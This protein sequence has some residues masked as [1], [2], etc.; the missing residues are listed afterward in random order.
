M[1]LS[2][3]R[4]FALKPPFVD[5]LRVFDAACRHRRARSAILGQRA[6]AQHDQLPGC[7]P[8]LSVLSGVGMIRWGAPSSAPTTNAVGDEEFMPTTTR[9]PMRS[10]TARKARKRERLVETIANARLQYGFTQQDLADA[11]GISQATISQIE[12]GKTAPGLA[13]QEA[14]LAAIARLTGVAGV[15]PAAGSGRW[16][17]TLS[18]F[19]S[20]ANF[21]IDQ[22]ADRTGIPKVRLSE[23]ENGRAPLGLQERQILSRVVGCHPEDLHSP[24][25]GVAVTG[26]AIF[27]SHDMGG[28]QIADLHP[29]A[30]Y[31]AL[32][33]LG[34]VEAPYPPKQLKPGDPEVE[35][36]AE[37]KLRRRR[38]GLSQ[39]QLAALAGISQPL[40][41]AIEAGKAPIP[42]AV[43]SALAQSGHR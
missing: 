11:S 42:E 39:A 31:R 21:T 16:V 30:R 23:V 41:S 12:A 33:E 36:A 9:R 34:V 17:Q 1:S 4:Q 13:T 15:D 28:R 7:S 6:T 37:L 3:P 20:E 8:P 2:Y 27:D 10:L 5:A 19:R 18:H 38:A 32:Y 35:T 26:G 22:L 29:R 25:P 24:T 43:L 40:L 14:I